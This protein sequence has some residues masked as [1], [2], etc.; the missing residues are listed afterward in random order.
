[1]GTISDCLHPKVNFKKKCIYMLTLLPKDVQTKYKKK[2]L[3]KEFF[4]FATDGATN[5]SANFRKN[6]KSLLWNT[7]GLG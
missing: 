5:V 4:S 2:I 3:I 6:S 1:M 7:Q